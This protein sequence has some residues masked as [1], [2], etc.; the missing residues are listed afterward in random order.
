MTLKV[1]RF[2][3]LGEASTI[4]ILFLL[5]WLQPKELWLAQDDVTDTYWRQEKVVF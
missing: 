3:A 2:A 4:I 5:I 1:V